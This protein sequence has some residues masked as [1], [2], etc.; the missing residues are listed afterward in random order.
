MAGHSAWLSSI[1]TFD[2]FVCGNVGRFQPRFQRCSADRADRITR[3]RHQELL[4]GAS[5]LGA[6]IALNNG[7]HVRN[8]RPRYPIFQS[9]TKRPRCAKLTLHQGRQPSGG[10]LPVGLG[11]IGREQR[12]RLRP[13]VEVPTG[14]AELPSCAGRDRDR[15][16][17]G[18]P[19]AS[20]RDVFDESP[21]FRPGKKSPRESESE[22]KL[23]RRSCIVRL[24]RARGDPAFSKKPCGRKRSRRASP[25]SVHREAR[26]FLD[27][28]SLERIRASE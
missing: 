27:L 24:K 7:R 18:S 19:G 3:M 22:R 9:G 10:F 1:R 5:V 6:A 13:R 11:G 21:P 15:A 17:P 20:G 25:A 23:R 14:R 12:N 4:F 28:V 2:K 16:R 8:M 26:I